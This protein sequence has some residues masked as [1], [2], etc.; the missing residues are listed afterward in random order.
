[1]RTALLQLLGIAA[2][3]EIGV[4]MFGPAGI[5]YWMTLRPALWILAATI[6]DAAITRA[7]VRRTHS[8]VTVQA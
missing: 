3:I 2:I 7:S 6:A 8:G 4:L 1:M 5:R